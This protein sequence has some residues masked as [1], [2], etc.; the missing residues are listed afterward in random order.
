[1][2]VAGALLVVLLI[3]VGGYLAFP[4]LVS[5]VANWLAPKYG[6]EH[7][8]VE[9]QRPGWSVWDIQRIELSTVSQ[10]VWANKIQVTYDPAELI[11]GRLLAIEIE[12]LE[13]ELKPAPTTSVEQASAPD[14]TVLA[15]LPMQ[16]LH[17]EELHL[18][19]PAI[20]LVMAGTLE[21][22]ED[23]LRFRL[24]ASES[25][26]NAPV[27]LTARL[28]ADGQFL[29]RFHTSQDKEDH[30]LE[31]RGGLL[32][33]SLAIAGSFDLGDYEL[34]LIAAI[35][36]VP[37]W[38]GFVRGDFGLRVDQGF[39]P[40]AFQSQLQFGVRPEA[41]N[42]IQ[43]LA[44]QG[45]VQW[46]PEPA[47]AGWNLAVTL[48]ALLPERG[49]A[50]RAHVQHGE[51][52]N[53]ADG[54]FVLSSADLESLSQVFGM[55]HLK[56]DVS[57]SFK[58]IAGPD[59]EVANAEVDASMKIALVY[60]GTTRV[61]AEQVTITHT[62]AESQRWQVSAIPFE[63]H[64]QD[65]GTALLWKS[66]EFMLTLDASEP[67]A[68]SM[69]SKGDLNWQDDETKVFI[70]ALSLEG[71]GQTGAA[72]YTAEVSVALQGQSVPLHVEVDDAF[73]HWR[74]NG[75]LNWVVT[76]PLLVS[77][78]G[79][80]S[81]YDIVGG[82]FHGNVKG[83]LKGEAMT[84][85]VQG[86]FKNGRLTYDDLVFTGF[87][88]TV[89]AKLLE[90]STVHA[91]LTDVSLAS[92]DPGVPIT[93]IRTGF[94]MLGD[95][96][97]LSATTGKLL[98][99][100]FAIAPFSYDMAG[101]DATLKIGLSGVELGAVLALEG[102]DIHGEGTLDG[103]IPVN[104]VDDTITVKNGTLR[105]TSKG[106]IRLA[107]NLAQS[108]NQ[109]GLDFALRALEDFQYETLEA[110]IDYDVKGDLLAAVR[111]R[112]RNAKIEKGRPIHY[113]LNISENLPTLLA[114]LRLQDEINERV[115][116]RVRQGV[117]R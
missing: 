116:K 46:L 115:E 30:A 108:V 5:K 95:L 77:T 50:L 22:G 105:N 48:D 1:M 58:V 72:G 104:I 82:T 99:G 18:R 91:D 13:I 34:A 94:S 44:M 8:D 42:T 98:G 64:Q 12:R 35:V 45:S 111:L 113:N 53:T 88:G 71:K 24:K 86:T 67:L 66:P 117:T 93:E 43:P 87:A 55:A 73:D 75:P 100:S 112:G 25:P 102:K 79:M 11:H 20:P 15:G 41:M 109:P 80:Q 106:V 26:L 14:P 39:N 19:A 7:V 3:L 32:G 9:V 85:D 96:V 36:D 47:T 51:T 28:D 29:A 81:D 74:F 84:T 37:V 38:T 56:G 2:V 49:T 97:N 61:S 62:A 92:F 76:R 21:L 59:L 60:D 23:Q 68:F 70:K 40:Q 10:R 69:L 83:R 103:Q 57:G 101:G 27:R 31:A 78:L 90:D 110:D 107:S 52:T 65:E 54:S 17:V 114:S 6:V 63:V 89:V 16:R 33:D 4:W